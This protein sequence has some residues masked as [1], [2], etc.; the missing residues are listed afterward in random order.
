MSHLSPLDIVDMGASC[1][2][3]AEARVFDFSPVA[4]RRLLGTPSTTQTILGTF[5]FLMLLFK[6]AFVDC[7]AESCGALPTAAETAVSTALVR[8]RSRSLPMDTVAGVPTRKRALAA[9]LSSSMSPVP[10]LRRA[11][12]ASGSSRELVS[13]VVRIEF[14]TVIDPSGP[15][16]GATGDNSGDQAG[17]G[18]MCQV[19]SDS[20][21]R[22]F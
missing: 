13:Q 14:N 20:L 17:I 18:E 19:L 11:V 10:S 21:I 16:E 3:I 7:E 1:P 2:G 5:V 15:I 9:L 22:K 6:S 12:I 4:L 8:A